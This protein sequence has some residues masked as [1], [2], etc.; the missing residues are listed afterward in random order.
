MSLA[1]E[2]APH[3]PYL[4]RFARAMTGQQRSGDAY[5]AAMLEALIADSALFPR[6]LGTRVGAYRTLVS[7]WN[8]VDV[9]GAADAPTTPVDDESGATRNIQAITP[10]ARQA[11]LLTAVEKFSETEAAQ[12]LDEDVAGLRAL[13]E[14]ANREIADLVATDVMIIEDEPLIALDIEQMVQGAG[15]SVTGIA[16]TYEEAMKLFEQQKPGMIL[17][18][19][20]LADGSSGIDA[21]ND[22]LERTSVP[23][24]F[25]TAFPERLLTGERREPTLLVTKPFQPDEVRALISQAIFFDR[26]RGTEQNV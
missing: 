13:V 11:L 10:R 23:V 15:H 22:I 14:E 4:R 17:A 7:M 12:I 16:R 5:V 20:Q 8:T 25:I 9:N 6:S 24:I 19:I 26:G 3:L 2:L 1:T 21:V 18:D